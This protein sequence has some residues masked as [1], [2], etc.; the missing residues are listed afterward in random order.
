MMEVKS[1]MVSFLVNRQQ[2]LTIKNLLTDLLTFGIILLPKNNET[3]QII[4]FARLSHRLDFTPCDLGRIQTCNLLS[5]NQVHYSVML[6]GQK[7]YM[8]KLRNIG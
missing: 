2:L 4:D 1:T 5:R 6:R 3:L 7:N 8:A